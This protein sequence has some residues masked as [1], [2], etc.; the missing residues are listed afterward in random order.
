MKFKNLLVGVLALSTLVLSGCGSSGETSTDSGTDTP[1]HE[2]TYEFK[3]FVWTETP[4]AYTAKAK[5][6]CKDDETHVKNYDAEMSKT[7]DA[8]TC[9]VAGA[10]HWKA[11][12]D[13][14]EGTKDEVLA[15]TGVHSAD[16]H[17]FCTS[18]GEYLGQHF[19]EFNHNYP[20]Q[21]KTGK[22]FYSVTTK[23]GERYRPYVNGVFTGSFEV[24]CQET[25]AGNPWSKLTLDSKGSF[26]AGDAKD[27][28]YYIVINS[29]S[30]NATP[31]GV[32]WIPDD[33]GFRNGA[34]TGSTLTVEQNYQTLVMYSSNDYFF[35]FEGRM[36]HSYKF[37]IEDGNHVEKDANVLFFH[38]D[39][40]GHPE[41]ISTTE[42]TA[43]LADDEDIYLRVSP[44]TGISNP[45]YRI[46]IA[47]CE[48]YDVDGFCPIYHNFV[49]KKAELEPA[50]NFIGVMEHQEE[51]Y[52]YLPYTP[53]HSYGFTI[54]N[55]ST[56]DFNFFVYRD[57]TKIDITDPSDSSLMTASDDNILYI[58]VYALA[59]RDDP[60][61]FT[62]SVGDHEYGEHGL[63]SCGQYTLVGQ[64]LT[65]GV[66][67]ETYSV[68]ATVPVFFRF[69]LSEITG[70][71]GKRNFSI[72]SESYNW[73]SASLVYY[74]GYFDASTGDW[75]DI[76]E[77][78]G[79][80]DHRNFDEDM[81]SQ[82]IGT[83]KD[84]YIYITVVDNAV[85]HGSVHDFHITN[86]G[87]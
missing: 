58:Y 5:Y 33:Y 70:E 76:E 51:S 1:A 50:E 32:S 86:V 9:S 19:D 28:T 47:S 17:G 56:S 36:F 39:A 10:N 77:T 46:V 62:V 13:G 67:A 11:S 40:Q 8:P 53:S 41:D 21:L 59:D 42:S 71:V 35:K 16:E 66:N 15:A 78:W 52:W 74:V 61:K 30:D 55:A 57:G 7:T 38:L 65:V 84:G 63:C 2:H 43:V 12:Y 49:G 79:G 87:S 85:Y 82:N 69:L 73:N 64:T 72:Y 60:V 37:E 25:T 68:S 24:Y 3:E 54:I 22:N 83:P 34:F 81:M 4:G 18:G 20:V 14:H 27:N 48:D 44:V 80:S 6:V 31:I 45:Y 23:K 26:Y 29:P 75:V